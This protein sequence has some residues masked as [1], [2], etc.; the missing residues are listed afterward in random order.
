MGNFT[1]W[2]ASLEDHALQEGQTY[3]LS[4]RAING[5]G[6]E[7]N[8]V[9]SDGVVIGKSEFVLSKNQ[10]GFFFFD[11]VEINSDGSRKA[12]SIKNTFATLQIPEGAVANKTRF[13]CFHVKE[14]D[15]KLENASIVDPGTVPPSK[16]FKKIVPFI[17]SRAIT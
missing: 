15:A 11:V 10:S 13:R 8:L 4:V 9:S 6:L 2:F 3:Y 1:T 5:A 16:V 14:I 12:S 17:F 7:S